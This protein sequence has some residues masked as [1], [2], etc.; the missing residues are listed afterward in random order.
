[1]TNPSNAARLNEEG[2]SYHERGDDNSAFAAFKDALESISIDS[3]VR[4][5]ASVSAMLSPVPDPTNPNNTSTARSSL[6]ASHPRTDEP[7]ICEEDETY[8]YDRFLV[9]E[10]EYASDPEA[11]SYCSAVIIFNMALV[12]QKRDNHVKTLYK[13]LFLYIVSLR[14]LRTNASE[15]FKNSDVVIAALNNQAMI[16]CMLKDYGK[17]RTVLGELWSLLRELRRR[18]GSLNKKDIDGIVQNILLLLQSPSL[19]AAA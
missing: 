1:M 6:V 4:T 3:H 18:P 8:L 14:H 7:I 9:F 5:G 19:A 16:F 15:R 10:P 13:A 17:A 12:F 2:A 11:A